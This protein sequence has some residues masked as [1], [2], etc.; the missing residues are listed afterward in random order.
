[1]NNHFKREIDAP[2]GAELTAFYR[3][4]TMFRGL[5]FLMGQLGVSQITRERLPHDSMTNSPEDYNSETIFVLDIFRRFALEQLDCRHQLSFEAHAL[6]YEI[7][8]LMFSAS[9]EYSHTDE[10]LI[11]EYEEALKDSIVN[12]TV[13]GAGLRDITVDD[14]EIRQDGMRNNWKNAYDACIPDLQKVV[15]KMKTWL[16]IVESCGD[17]SA[18]ESQNELADFILTDR[19][20]EV[21]TVLA[22]FSEKGQALTA[23]QIVTELDKL[24]AKSGKKLPTATDESVR[25]ICKKLELLD[26]VRNRPGAGYISTKHFREDRQIDKIS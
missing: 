8:G 25:K 20:R 11:T 17:F 7:L 9:R 21:N 10:H 3:F 16:L 15:Y 12:S 2:D 18:E 1:M 24:A 23:K 4:S 22:H 6:L 26:W 14:F 5:K 19:Q 13:P